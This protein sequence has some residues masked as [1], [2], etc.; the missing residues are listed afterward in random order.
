MGLGRKPFENSGERNKFLEILEK[1]LQKRLL[2]YPP[3]KRDR[4]WDLFG[5]Q[6]VGKR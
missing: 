4:E 1:I 5:T 6:G 2:F 3:F